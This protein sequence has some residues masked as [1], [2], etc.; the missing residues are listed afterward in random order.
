MARK[1]TTVEEVPIVEEIVVEKEAVE[2]VP[3]VEGVIKPEVLVEVV[4][5][6][7]KR[8]V[9]QRL[10]AWRPKTQLGKNVFEKKITNI[11]EILEKGIKIK[12]PEIVDFLL[13]D[14]ENE[15]SLIGGRPGKGGGNQ[16]TPI[17]ISAKMHRSGRR[18]TSSAFAIVGNNNGIVG[19]GKG[20]GREGR[21]AVEKAIQ[22]AKLNLIKVEKGCGSWECGC[23][24][25]HSIPFKIIGKAGS[26]TIRLLPAPRGVGLAV[27]NETK[28]ILRLAGIK[29]IW[30]KT[31][32]NT[33]TRYNLVK[34]VYNALK[35]LHK[36]KLGE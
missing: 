31:M 7:I 12:E 13:P 24:G 3:I 34:A 16:K 19:V 36:Y 17:R 26:V 6:V 15:L 8:E 4:E 5:R 28:K 11:N 2:A 10:A 22:K 9:E 25:D 35:N 30:G 29:D 20:R 21:L 14:M 27:D 1:K 23:G 33:G 18:M 32:G